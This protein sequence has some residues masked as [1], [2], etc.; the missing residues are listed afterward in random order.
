M[1][2]PTYWHRDHAVLVR[3]RHPH[4]V[5]VAVSMLRTRASALG[6]V[7]RCRLEYGVPR[8]VVREL[9]AIAVRLQRRAS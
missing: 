7:E 6:D 5:E 3:P 4:P 8:D 2:R 1:S 9:R